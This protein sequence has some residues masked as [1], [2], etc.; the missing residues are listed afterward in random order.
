VADV[1]FD[2]EGAQVEINAQAL[3]T[4][5]RNNIKTWL[6]NQGFDVSKIDNTI[7]DRRK[8]LFAVLRWLLNR[9][10]CD[11]AMALDGYDAS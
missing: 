1:V 8:L 6:T 5:Q 2:A 9:A 4:A 10:D 11:L 3:T 7:T